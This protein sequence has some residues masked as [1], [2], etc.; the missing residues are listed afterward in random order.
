MSDRHVRGPS[1]ARKH[2]RVRTKATTGP[3][4]TGGGYERVRTTEHDP[5]HP[6]DGTTVVAYAHHRLLA[7]AWDID[8]CLPSAGYEGVVDLSALEGMDVHHDCPEADAGRGVEW[9]NREAC[10][11]VE[12]HAAHSSITNAEKRAYA[13]DAKRLR[14]G[15][16]T[17][18]TGPSCSECHGEV[19]ARVAG[20]PYCLEHASERA[21]ATGE[22]VEIL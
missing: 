13:E 6:S 16:E 1:H 20:E 14:D 3:R 7:L 5:R 22:T 2:A 15:D 8:D 4:D 11:N 21:K 9:D 19:D 18:D 10:L 12:T 17:L